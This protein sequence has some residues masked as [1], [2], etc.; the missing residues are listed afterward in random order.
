MRIKEHSKPA[1]DPLARIKDGA[2]LIV[3]FTPSDWQLMERKLGYYVGGS[4]I[5]ELILGVF[6]GDYKI[7]KR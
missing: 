3:T 4:Q 1:F 7:V 6:V 2:P 5:R